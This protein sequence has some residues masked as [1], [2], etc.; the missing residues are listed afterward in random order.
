MRHSSS[1]LPQDQVLQFR[2]V[3]LT[4]G[5]L[6]THVALTAAAWTP[7][8]ATPLADRNSILV[9]NISGNG[10]VVLWNYSASAPAT[11]GIRIEDGGYKAT[12]LS[13]TI[14]VYGRMLSGTG[15]VCV[16]EVA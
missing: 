12:I 11:E 2:P 4:I 8:P 3:G 5:G 10:G 16:D 14:I 1:A 6:I 9:Q 7:L 15:T 13:D